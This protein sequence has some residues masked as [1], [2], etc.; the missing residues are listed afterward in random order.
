MIHLE[1]TDEE[2]RTRVNLETAQIPWQELQGFFAAGKVINASADLDLYQGC[3]IL[4]N[5]NIVKDIIEFQ[6]VVKKLKT[7]I[8]DVIFA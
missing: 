5:T 4:K 6:A 3:S 7:D 8:F 1:E 2:F